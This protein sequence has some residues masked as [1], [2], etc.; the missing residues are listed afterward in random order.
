M[1]YR[2]NPD[3]VIP[4]L[5][6]YKSIRH[7]YLW[8]KDPEL[9]PYLRK[10]LSRIPYRGIGEFHVFGP[11]AG[12]Q[13]VVKMIELARE[14]KLALHPHAN[15]EAMQTI[16]A[17]AHDI[18]VIWAHSGFDVPLATL[19]EL[20]N[21][22]PGLYLELSLREG[23][24]NNGQLTTQWKTF[25]NDYPKRFLLGMDTYI[26]RRWANLHVLADEA[27]NWL[28]QLPDT[29]AEDIAKN[30]LNRLFPKDQ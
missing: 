18:T 2:E 5:R 21:K 23:M 17:Q 4:M 12:N 30:N 26:P 22:Y 15:L 11:D 20:L 19:R 14:R 29:V 7:R 13:A 10:H 9:I 1:L 16:L 8:F 28:T 27:R 24:L 3:V 6:P 25:L